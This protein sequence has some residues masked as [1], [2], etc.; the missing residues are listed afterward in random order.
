MNSANE[1]AAREWLQAR[2]DKM[3]NDIELMRGR[4]REI[5]WL[6]TQ[7]SRPVKKQH[8]PRGQLKAVASVVK[9]GTR[10]ETLR[11]CIPHIPAH[12]TKASELAQKMQVPKGTASSWLSQLKT[13]GVL[14]HEDHRY[15]LAQ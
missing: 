4:L 2:R 1:R 7:L 5:D 11:Q 9:T 3:A 8:A 12:G 10:I 15:R 6:L 14:V 13:H